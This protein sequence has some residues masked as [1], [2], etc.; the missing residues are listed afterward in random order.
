MYGPD[1]WKSALTRPLPPNAKPIFL[2]FARLKLMCAF[3]SHLSDPDS[4]G[5][6]LQPLIEKLHQITIAIEQVG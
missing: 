4:A 5:H 3:E 6:S 1:G 2:L